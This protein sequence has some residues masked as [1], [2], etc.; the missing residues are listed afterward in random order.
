MKVLY[1][2]SGISSPAG[3]GT[4]YIQNLIVT[5]SRRGVNATIVTP[6]L[7]HSNK[8][9][10]DWSKKQY[11]IYGIRIIIINTPSWL[12]RRPIL[13][14]MI[15]NVLSILAVIRLLKKEHYDV[16]H[17]FSSSPIILFRSLLFKLMFNM[18][19]I[20]TLS[21]YN[22]SFLGNFKW[23]KIL[24][25]AK[26]YVVPSKEIMSIL[27]KIGIPAQKIFF[28]P[29]GVKIDVFIKK[30][31]QSEEREKLSLPKKKFILTYY[32]TLTK[33]KGAM[34]LIHAYQSLEQ[35]VR[36]NIHLVLCVVWRGS[37]EH[38]EIKSYIVS[39]KQKSITLLERFVD[40]RGLIWASDAVI[41]PQQTGS[42]TTIPPISVI[43]TLAAGKMLIATDIIGNREIINADCGILV[44]PKNPVRLS[45]AIKKVFKKRNLLG[46]YIMQ[47]SR[48]IGKFRLNTVAKQYLSLYHL[49][50]IPY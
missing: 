24:N 5:L 3:W 2:V 20:F 16:I 22:N 29:P 15:A 41:L 1:L 7:L 13:H 36:D 12:K 25:F 50:F 49:T 43:E 17:E 10:R 38:S 21:V 35:D 48:T 4:E 37:S 46:K 45:Q 44:P 14:L 6:L 26:Y 39:L 23:F 42:G 27:L 40:I 9:W 34:D 47:N 11:D 19:T 31:N 18:P 28:I 33:E 32:G 30:R 8:D